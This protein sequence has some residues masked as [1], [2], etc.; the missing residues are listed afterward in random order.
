[1]FNEENIWN[2]FDGFF[3]LTET[4]T[5]QTVQEDGVDSKTSFM[6]D[7]SNDMKGHNEEQIF[8]RSHTVKTG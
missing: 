6:A 8:L 4:C 3:L 2:P 7:G 1:M 5:W